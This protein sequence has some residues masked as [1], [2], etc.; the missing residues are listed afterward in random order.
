MSIKMLCDFCERPLEREE[1]GYVIYHTRNLNTRKIFPSLCKSCADKLDTVI[2]LAED[3]TRKRCQDF[4]HWTKINKA[5]RE[6]LG[7]KG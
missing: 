5:R 3:A 2:E 4:G 7:T 6:Q 1:R